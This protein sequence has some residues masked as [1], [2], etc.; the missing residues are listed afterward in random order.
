MEHP[1]KAGGDLSAPDVNSS[2]ANLGDGP[3]VDVAT[4]D[5]HGSWL[6]EASGDEAAAAH[7][8]KW[9]P[10]LG[11]VDLGQPDDLADGPVGAT[12]DGQRVAIGYVHNNARREL[13]EERGRAHSQKESCNMPPLR[14]TSLPLRRQTRVGEASAEAE[15]CG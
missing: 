15:R 7:R 1:R 4:P 3:P 2:T 11:R 12:A 6:P 9:L 14:L 13:G 10:V 8:S 5:C